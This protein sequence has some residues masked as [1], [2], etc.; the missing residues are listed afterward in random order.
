MIIK[1]LLRKIPQ[2]A[3][4]RKILV[5]VVMIFIVSLLSA[6]LPASPMHHMDASDC[7]MQTSCSNCFISA[8]IDSPVLNFYSS[9]CGEL[10]ET[11]NHFKPRKLVPAT[12]PPKN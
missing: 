1:N 12:P 11:A 2:L 10:L 6:N 3:K 7:A 9:F 8:S 5:A 4:K